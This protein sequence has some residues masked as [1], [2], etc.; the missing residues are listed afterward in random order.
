MLINDCPLEIESMPE[1]GSCLFKCIEKSSKVIEQI[2]R[3]YLSEVVTEH[4]LE[5]YRAESEV[6]R[7]PHQPKSLRARRNNT[8]SQTN[9]GEFIMETGLKLSDLESLKKAARTKAS[10]PE[11]GL[12]KCLWGDEFALSAIGDFLDI[13]FLLIDLTPGSTQSNLIF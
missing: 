7:A 9:L 2:Q 12:T 10:D 3:D 4:H 1:D 6:Y 8:T 13:T 11:G 5:V